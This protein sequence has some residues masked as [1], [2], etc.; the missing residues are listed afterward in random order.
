VPG[1]AIRLES[2]E[3]NDIA[4][5]KHMNDAIPAAILRMPKCPLNFPVC[6]SQTTTPF[7]LLPVA[8][9]RSLA[10]IAAK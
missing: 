7:P 8:R 10:K 9:K 4:P 5:V 2:G 3:E 1:A 6:A